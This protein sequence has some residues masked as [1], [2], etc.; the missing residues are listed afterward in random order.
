[1]T[2]ERRSQA[3]VRAKPC[4]DWLRFERLPAAYSHPDRIADLLPEGLPTRFRDRLQGSSRLR[5]RLS[6]L[7]AKRRALAPCTLQDLATPEGRFVQ[8]E[9]EDLEN[10]LRR[11]GAIW[12]ARTIRKIILSE[13]LRE[14]IERLGRDN[15]RAALRFIELAP[16]DDG[17]GDGDA[18]DVDALMGLIERDSL[19]AVNAWCRQQPAALGERL[20]LKLRPCPDVDDE[21]PASH[22]DRGVMIVDRVVMTLAVDLHGETSHVH[23]RANAHD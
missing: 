1:M 17:E 16:E 6:A 20:R 9:G 7:L 19:I 8:L 21:P 5:P 2:T 12:H 18:V 13:R 3:A 11:I 14:L 23:D 10:A 4:R 15:H 22:R